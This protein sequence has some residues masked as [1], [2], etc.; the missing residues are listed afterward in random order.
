MAARY[1]FVPILISLA[2]SCV[3]CVQTVNGRVKIFVGLTAGCSDARNFIPNQLVP[4]YAQYGQFLD[5]EFVPWARTRR[6]EDGSLSCQFGVPDC[7]ANRLLRCTLDHLKANNTAQLE[8]MACEYR[9]P[10]PAFSG[11][12][13]CATNAG[14]G[15]TQA[16]FCVNNPQLDTLDEEA[17]AKGTGPIQTINFV[18]SIV[19]NDDIDVDAHWQGF[20][21]LSSV[22]CFALADDPTTGVLGCQI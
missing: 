5:L 6:L 19:F 9:A 22:V 10:F 17:E 14:Y 7:W 11:S 12:F 20:S 1:I 8:Y 15:L 21:R 2:F 18:P 13:Q 4:T 16:D 3:N